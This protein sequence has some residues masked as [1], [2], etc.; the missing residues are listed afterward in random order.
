MVKLTE[1]IFAI[2]LPE[3]VEIVAMEAGSSD[4]LRYYPKNYNN[5]HDTRRIELPQGNWRFLFTTN[6]T[7]V[8]DPRK[9]VDSIDSEGRGPIYMNYERGM[10]LF[11]KATSSLCSLLR[12]KGCSEGNYAIL[13]KQI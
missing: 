10:Y 7:T 5:I 4:A 3:G 12:S 9:V 6:Y 8:D 11:S 2:E 13:E 1:K